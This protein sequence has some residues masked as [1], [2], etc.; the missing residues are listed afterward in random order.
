MQTSSD[1]IV[2]IGA[3]IAGLSA[4]L[5]LAGAGREVMVLERAATPGGKMRT[6]PSAAGP[7]DAGPTVMTL[8]PV[9][10]ALFESVG[11]RLSDHV[12]L[13]PETVLARHWW[14]DGS[15]LDLHADPEVSAAAVRDFA[16]AKAE[17][18][19]RAFSAEAARLFQTFDAPI[20]RSA[21]PGI[22]GLIPRVLAAPG[23][24]AALLPTATLAGR[25]RPHFGDPRLRLLFGR[26]ATYVGGSPYRS[27]AVL[28]LIWQAEAQ[29]VWRIEGGMHRLA[30]AVA[31]LAEAKGATLRY[32]TEVARIEIQG[33]RV[34]A[35]QTA[36]GQRIPCGHVVFNGDPRALHVGLLGDPARRA[37]PAPGVA[38]RSLSAYVWT[39]AAAPEGQDL[40]HHN[41][42]FGDDPRDEF[43][44]LMRG[45]MPVDPTLYIC[46]E[47]RGA[48]RAPAGPERFEIIM[49]GPPVAGP[50]PD[51]EFET[52]RTRTFARLAQ[53]G[54]R[55]TPTPGRDAL[56]TPHDFARLFPASN[57]SLYGRSPHGMMATF[58]RPRVRT[59]LPGLYLAGGG[60]HPGAGIPMATLS[61][62]HA[63][64][65]ILS[66]RTSRSMSRPTVM[67]GGMST[68]SRTAARGPSRSSPS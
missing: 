18:E 56:T 38:A 13:H 34:A 21:S 1:R 51:R 49:N 3:G 33:G 43:A 28:G 54:L 45:Q 15:R 11:A 52:C 12:T 46:A 39:F 66:A 29:G 64:E 59:S 17:G 32:G 61:G 26:Y 55:F 2:V 20:M 8:R 62:Q 48:G 68:V 41:V 53:M 25:L 5:R 67:R 40:V 50:A 16:G 30:R 6:V 47:D 60:V 44:P 35:V 36:S 19:F 9:F 37:V 57:G 42:F 22:A 63:A 23:L 14:S 10:E 4:A 58:Q 24:L 27:P 65:A 7:V 31:D